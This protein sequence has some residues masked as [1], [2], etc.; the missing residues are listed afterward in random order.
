M[1]KEFEVYITKNYYQL[2]SIAKKITN[3]DDMSHELLHECIVQL[4][5]KNDIVLKKYDDNNIR[6][7]IT[8]VLRTNWYSKTSPFHYKIRKE[9]LK[10]VD[11]TS[12]FDVD[13][14]QETFEIQNLYDI[15]E[16]SYSE[17]DIF[18]KSLMDL[19]L[20]LG[21]LKKVSQSTKIPLVSISRYINEAKKNIRDDIK[22]NLYE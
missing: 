14:E 16:V 5:D 9:R 22:K 12:Y 4:Y 8:A 15:L 10:Y 11:L 6:Y 7:Y 3:D 20:T 18:E 17:L 19:Y 1:R 13:K 21:S 2:K